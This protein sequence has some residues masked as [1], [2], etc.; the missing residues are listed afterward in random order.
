ME[1]NKKEKEEKIPT[2]AEIMDAEIRT[3]MTPQ[4]IKELNGLT[5]TILQFLLRWQ[6]KR[7][8][9]LGDQL[10]EELKEFLKEVYEADNDRICKSVAEIVIAQNKKMF[11]FFGS[12]EK[13]MNEIAD[14]IRTI[15]G[16]IQ[17]IKRKLDEVERRQD[18][19]EKRL[20]TIERKV[21]EHLKNYPNKL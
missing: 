19:F 18:A 4:A 3:L 1:N 5:P 7:D 16:D 14:N 8:L 20:E 11:G 13:S 21:A 15:K 17:G 9:V 12:I 2:E 10:K 6:N